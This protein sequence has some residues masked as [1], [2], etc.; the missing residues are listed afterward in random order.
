MILLIPKPLTNPCVYANANNESR[1]AHSA[2]AENHVFFA[3]RKQSKWSFASLYFHTT[4][5]TVNFFIWDFA[6]DSP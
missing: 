1:V 6:R 3:N 5:E 4:I 2:A